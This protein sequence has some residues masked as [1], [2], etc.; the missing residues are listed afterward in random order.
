ML[1]RSLDCKTSPIW[2]YQFAP[3]QFRFL[4]ASGP[5]VDGIHFIEF[6]MEWSDPRD[7]AGMSVVDGIFKKFDERPWRRTQNSSSYDCGGAL[8]KGLKMIALSREEINQFVSGD[9]VGVLLNFNLNK[10]YF[11]KNGRYLGKLGGCLPLPE[12]SNVNKG[13]LVVACVPNRSFTGAFECGKIYSVEG[14]LPLDI[15]EW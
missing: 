13:L 8:Y 6:K 3:I 5:F 9:V 14:R 15:P 12:M 10:V 7:L 2:S 4:V 1:R 11:Y